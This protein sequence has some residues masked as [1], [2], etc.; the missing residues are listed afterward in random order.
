MCPKLDVKTQQFRQHYTDKG[1][2]WPV[3]DSYKNPEYSDVVLL[4]IEHSYV[5]E[6][7]TK[8]GYV[9]DSNKTKLAI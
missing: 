8:Y 7:N 9:G 4:S 3:F 6:L 5:G 1:L 2:I